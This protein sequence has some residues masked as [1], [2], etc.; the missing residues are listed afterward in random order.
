MTLGEL[1]GLAT[2]EKKGLMP[3]GGFVNAGNITTGD[4][5]EVR[6]GYGYSYGTVDDSGIYGPFISVSAGSSKLQIKA[7]HTGEILKFR[8]KRA[9]G[10]MSWSNWRK[11]LTE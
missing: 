3:A 2:Q 8:T 9:D 5:K 4:L 11:I 1:I 6:D 7:D 10:D